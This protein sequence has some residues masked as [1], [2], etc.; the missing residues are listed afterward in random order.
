[1]D[2]VVPFLEPSQFWSLARL[3]GLEEFTV[4]VMNKRSSKYALEPYLRMD[5]YRDFLELCPGLKSF[6]L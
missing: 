1:M 4:L 5:G 6:V 2:V 3:R